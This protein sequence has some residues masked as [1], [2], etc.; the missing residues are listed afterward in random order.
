MK[1]HSFSR[2]L[3]LNLA[4]SAAMAASAA[5]SS[6]PETL[7]RFGRQL[8]KQQLAVDVTNVS[9]LYAGAGCQ[10]V[11]NEKF[12]G[13]L[14]R[15]GVVSG[16]EVARDLNEKLDNALMQIE[17]QVRIGTLSSN[18]LPSSD[19]V[20]AVRKQIESLTHGKSFVFSSASYSY[21]SESTLRV[22]TENTQGIPEKARL[23]L[24][25]EEAYID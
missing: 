15:H 6:G 10:K 8:L 13:K 23:T 1:S 3:T 7:S 9:T 25:S 18:A 24:C 11:L 22:F 19:R 4:L 20:A 14:Q 2:F 21:Y 16:A 17:E 12:D 5:A